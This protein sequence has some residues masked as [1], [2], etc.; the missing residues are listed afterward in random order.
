M[1]DMRMEKNNHYHYKIFIGFIFGV[2]LSTT[3]VYA[4]SYMGGGI[5]LTY[6][7]SKS[8]ISAT[9]VQEALDEIYQKFCPKGY[10]CV[11]K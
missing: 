4:V 9:N 7:N 3:F 2:V 1:E 11:R 10:I 8:E 6:D 5:D